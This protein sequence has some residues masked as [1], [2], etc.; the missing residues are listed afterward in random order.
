[1]RRKT[2][3][4]RLRSTP[5]Y[6]REAF[7]L[8]LER[9]GYRVGFGS[10]APAPGDVLVIWNRKHDDHRLALQFEA[11]DAPVIVAENAYITPPSCKKMFALAR[12]HHLGAGQWIESGPE[13]W[14]SF[15]IDLAPWRKTGDHILV[16]PQRGIGEPGVAMPLVWPRDIRRD[17]PKATKRPIRFRV[18]PGIHTSI[19]IEADLAGAHCVVTWAS[20]GGVKA[21][22][23]GVPVF[24]G[25]PSWIGAGAAVRGFADLEAPRMDDAARLRVFERLA[26]AQAFPEEIASGE[27]LQRLIG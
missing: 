21:L 5:H 10:G 3:W 23:A 14:A 18:H 25:L 1:M 12:S 17:L 22:A 9:L 24:F 13:R 20:G 16:L 26:W 8:G 6:R 11:I 7:T 15:G 4:L 19:P 2:A 27:A